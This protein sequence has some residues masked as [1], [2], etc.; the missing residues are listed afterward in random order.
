MYH[1]LW[2]FEYSLQLLLKITACLWT[3]I[4]LQI[5]WLFCRIVVSLFCFNT[6]LTPTPDLSSSLPTF[7]FF[8]SYF[9]SIM[10]LSLGKIPV[11]IWQFRTDDI[12]HA[13]YLVFC[14]GTSLHMVS[15]LSCSI[16]FIHALRKYITGGDHFYPCPCQQQSC[17]FF[18]FFTLV[19][20]NRSC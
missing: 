1:F 5:L 2:V 9:Y 13:S 7:S 12:S 19:H 4:V 3:C 8:T 14:V 17:L 18:V 6:S 11:A 16:T 15:S 10:F 20:Y